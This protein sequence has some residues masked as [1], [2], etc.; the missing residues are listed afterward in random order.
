MK[1]QIKTLTPIHIGNGETLKPLSYV[2]DRSFVYVLNM[3]NF[4]ESLTGIQKQ[5]YLTWLEP[6]LYSLSEITD[7]MVKAR[8]NPEL[9]RD[10]N[11]VIQ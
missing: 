11:R 4:F 6:I 10:L 3:D 2:S 1:L 8:D 5:K 7:K 9:K